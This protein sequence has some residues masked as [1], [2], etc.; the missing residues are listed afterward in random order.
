MIIAHVFRYSLGGRGGGLDRVGGGRSLYVHT[1]TGGRPDW[2]W[3]ITIY[4]KYTYNAAWLT[5]SPIDR[6]ILTF[7]TLTK[8]YEFFFE[9][10]YM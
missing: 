3:E 5:A 8:Q 10:V 9:N 4:N 6:Q 7:Q 1:T 2:G